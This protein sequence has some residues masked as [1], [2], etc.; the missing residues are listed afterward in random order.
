LEMTGVGGLHC[1]VVGKGG[2]DPDLC[3]AQRTGFLLW[4]IGGG[5]NGRRYLL[6]QDGFCAEE[7]VVGLGEA[8]GF[9]S[10]SLQ[11]A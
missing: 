9:V 1:W 5:G 4:E 3:L 7:V 10:D 8:V 11:Q 6:P 2:S